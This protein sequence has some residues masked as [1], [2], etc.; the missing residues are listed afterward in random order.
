[1]NKDLANPNNELGFLWKENF[2]FVRHELDK[3]QDAQGYLDYLR[4]EFGQGL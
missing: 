2:T 4:S 3:W 1:M